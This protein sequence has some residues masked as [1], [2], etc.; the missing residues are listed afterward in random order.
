M[1]LLPMDISA[2]EF[3]N[4]FTDALELYG[5]TPIENSK[6]SRLVA[7]VAFGKGEHILDIGSYVSIYPVVLRLLG[8]EITI[9]DS[10]PQRRLPGKSEKIDYVLENIYKKVGI[11]II[12]EDVYEISLPKNTFDRI[13]AFEVFEH[14]V[15]SPRPIL[16]KI[17]GSLR[18]GGKIIMSV[19]NIVRL[20]NRLKVMLG[21]SPLPNFEDFYLNGNPFTGHRREMTTGEV[22]WM[23]I[24]SGFEL[25][26]VFTTNITVPTPHNIPFL[27]KLYYVFTDFPLLPSNLR[28]SVF[29]VARKPLS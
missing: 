8:M 2:E 19:P 25:E 9:L 21:K 13:S 23:M 28:K 18:P 6:R 5:N 15:D 22:R 3:E 4:A 1:K 29:A 27:K 26:R 16:G 12:E 10:F 17:H 7:S 24:N 20:G 11:N 14:L